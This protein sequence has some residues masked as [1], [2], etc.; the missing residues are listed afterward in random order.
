MEGLFQVLAP[1]W[2]TPER[3]PVSQMGRHRSP[4]MHVATADDQGG[5]LAL[6]ALA[7]ARRGD[8]RIAAESRTIGLGVPVDRR[9]VRAPRRAKK[10]WQRI[11]TQADVKDVRIHDLR[12]TLGSWLAA[13]RY[14]LPLIGRVLNHSQPSATAIYAR[15]DLEP[16]RAALEANASNA[17]RYDS[18]G[19]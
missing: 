3:T 7:D 14:G 1:S 12:R 15:L 19:R 18:R 2:P 4:D 13:N 16:V 17:R 11:R 6:A 8:S 5:A 9:R 10:A